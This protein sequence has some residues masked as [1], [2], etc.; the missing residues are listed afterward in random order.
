[1]L[2]IVRVSV[3]I[4][5]TFMYVKFGILFKYFILK[6]KQVNIVKR[7]SRSYVDVNRHKSE[8]LTDNKSSGNCTIGWILSLTILKGIHTLTILSINTMY[9]ASE[10]R[11]EWL[12]ITY[13]VI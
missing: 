13:T 3:L 9:I 6:R 11:S 12:L 1:M 4:I 2:I 5:D 7:T 8:N 10:K